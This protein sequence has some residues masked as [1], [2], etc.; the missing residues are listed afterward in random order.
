MLKYNIIRYSN[1]LISFGHQHRTHRDQST[2]VR[3]SVTG[4]VDEVLNS[5]NEE[6]IYPDNDHTG[7]CKFD[8]TKLKTIAVFS[9]TLEK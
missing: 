9:R 8:I 3:P 2:A 7:I 4:T 6:G 5:Q 1:Y